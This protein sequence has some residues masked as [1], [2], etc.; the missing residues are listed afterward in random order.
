MIAI[1]RDFYLNIYQKNI[2]VTNHASYMLHINKYHLY[3]QSKFSEA[4]RCRTSPR[5]RSNWV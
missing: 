2:R 5:F 3:H 1:I 4:F